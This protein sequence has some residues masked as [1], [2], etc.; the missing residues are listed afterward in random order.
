MFVDGETR[1]TIVSGPKVTATKEV[2]ALEA[3]ECSSNLVDDE[4]NPSRKKVASVVS[5]SVQS[6]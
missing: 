4:Q 6:D 3:G 5:V 1:R 2:A